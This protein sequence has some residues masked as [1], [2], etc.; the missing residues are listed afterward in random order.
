[1]AAPRRANGRISRWHAI[2]NAQCRCIGNAQWWRGGSGGPRHRDRVPSTVQSVAVVVGRATGT[3]GRRGTFARARPRYRRERSRWFVGVLAGSPHADDPIVRVQDQE[4]FA[5]SCLERRC[6][7]RGVRRRVLVTH[8]HYVIIS[9]VRV[10]AWQ[11]PHTPLF[12]Q[13][14]AVSKRYFLL[15]KL[16]NSSFRDFLGNNETE[17]SVASLVSSYVL[18]GLTSAPSRS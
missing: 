3:R 16:M 14:D 4:K 5:H 11:H 1:M 13:P 6:A 17:T 7:R 8:V 2:G 9:V 12:S 10:R 15:K 18:G